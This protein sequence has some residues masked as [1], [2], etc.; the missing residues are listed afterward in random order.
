MNQGINKTVPPRRP[1]GGN[2]RNMLMASL[3]AALIALCAQIA[4]PLPLVPVNLALLPVFLAGFLLK[5]RWALASVGLYLLMGALG[6]PVFSGLRGGPQVLFGPTGGYLLGYL[7]SAGGIAALKNKA[8]SFAGRLL[9]CLFALLTCYIPG[10]L[11]L[12][13]LTGR[14]LLDVLSF[15]VLPFIPGDLL[16]SLAASL[17][18]PA[19]QRAL[20]ASRVHS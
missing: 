4:I 18:V 8:G 10:T 2:L 5:G 17:L 11:W 13:Y 6:L 3:T 15:A 1:S 16:K 19:L 12:L 7:L 14:P 20:A 9:L